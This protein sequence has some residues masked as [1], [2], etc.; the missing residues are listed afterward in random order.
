MFSRK[1]KKGI[2]FS[3]MA[4]V[5]SWTFFLQ[6]SKCCHTCVSSKANPWLLFLLETII[7]T[8][9]SRDPG[10]SPCSEALI[11]N[12]GSARTEGRSKLRKKR[13]SVLPVSWNGEE[14]SLVFFFWSTFLTG[15]FL[16]I[17]WRSS[18]FK[19][20]LWKCFITILCCYLCTHCLLDL[21]CSTHNML[22][23]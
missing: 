12:S 18:Y 14:K 2:F 20:L 22:K 21:L 23:I 5:W 1:K 3:V 6:W 9:C 16:W 8:D 17:L 11:A 7:C 15:N 10:C 13:I 4:E 19:V